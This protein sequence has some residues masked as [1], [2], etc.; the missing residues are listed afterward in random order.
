MTT[1]STVSRNGVATPPLP[2]PS[3]PPSATWAVH[4]APASCCVRWRVGALEFMY[5]LRGV[6]DAELYQRLGRALPWLQALVVGL[7]AQ[8]V[9]PAEAPGGP[10]LPPPGMPPSPASGDLSEGWCPVHQVPM[11]YR[12]NT[13]GSWYSHRLSDGTYCKG[14]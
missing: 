5:T 10:G 3:A 11:E 4:E 9:P 2:A 12:S 7:E 6:D 8:A 13:K 1:S 14:K